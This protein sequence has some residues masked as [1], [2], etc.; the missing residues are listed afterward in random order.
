MMARAMGASR[1]SA[2][3]LQ[4]LMKNVLNGMQPFD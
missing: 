3:S 1:T 4:N 2:G